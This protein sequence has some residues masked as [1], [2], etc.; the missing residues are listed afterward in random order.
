MA[1]SRPDERP[2]I[3]ASRGGARTDAALPDRKT[4]GKAVRFPAADGFPL[5]GTLFEGDGDGPLVLVSSATAVPQ[6]LY[7]GF[8]GALVTAGARA[9]LTYD[10]RGTGASPRPHGWSRRIDYKH[11]ALQDFPAAFDALQAAAPGHPVVGVGQSYGGHALGLSGVSDRFSRYAMVASMTASFRLLDDRL[12][13]ARMNLVGVPVSLLFRDTPRW[14]GIGEP[15]PSSCF[16]DWARWCRM[17]NYFFDD[18]G[19]PETARFAQVRTPILAIGLTDD[20]WATRRAM[21][22]FLARH[23]GAPVEHRRVSPA[24]AG[25]AVGH[26]GF[27]RSRFSRTLWPPLVGWLL[28]GGAVTLGEPG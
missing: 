25:G 10:Y 16:R 1:T 5:G 14:L 2:D 9:V 11:W 21:A 22:D 12:A 3:A 6:R 8:A 17:K 23:A 13:W 24:E 26:L 15:I 7:A 28:A 18:P 4:A 27:F 20:A 19:L